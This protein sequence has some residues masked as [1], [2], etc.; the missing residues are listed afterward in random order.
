[1]PKLG[2]GC[3]ASLLGAALQ[4]SPVEACSPPLGCTGSGIFPADGSIP[5]NAPAIEWWTASVGGAAVNPSLAQIERYNEASMMWTTL[6][7]DVDVTGPGR[8]AL[9]PRTPFVPDGRYRVGTGRQCPLDASLPWREFRASRAAAMPRTLGALQSTIPALQEIPHGPMVGGIC[10]DTARAMVT[11]VSV[12]LSADAEPWTSLL[13][14]EVLVDGMPFAGI[15]EQGS[16]MVPP[17]AGGTHQGRGR[18]RL[19]VIC[20]AAVEGGPVHR[21]WGL[22]E[23]EH[24][25]VFRARV[26][27]TA[28][29][30]ETA[31]LRVELRCP[32]LPMTDAGSL[33]TDAATT[34]VTDLG[35]APTDLGRGDVPSSLDAAPPVSAGGCGCTVARPVRDRVAAP[36][37]LALGLLRARRRSGGSASGQRPRRTRMRACASA[38]R[39]AR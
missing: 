13:T 25:V 23:G 19:A 33:A 16:P 17:P 5:A 10:A 6:E 26:A 28:T 7:H 27:G 9:R 2:L 32:G 4:A 34:I 11:S 8:V 39:V 15:V 38:G 3:L 24:V 14:Y 18:A 37:L 21:A 31:P 35:A 20:G 36:I 30:L 29:R 22:A 1:M 12:T